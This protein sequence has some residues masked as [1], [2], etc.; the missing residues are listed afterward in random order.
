MDETVAVQEIDIGSLIIDTIN[1]LCQ[2]LFSSI[3]TEIFPLLDKVV[4]IKKDI[5]TSHLERIVGTDTQTGLLVL[6]NALLFAFLIYYG[7][8]LLISSYSGENIES[9]YK[10]FLRL[11]LVAIFM[12]FSLTICTYIIDATSD[13]TT[14]ICSLG[15]NIFGNKIDISF[16]SLIETVSYDSGKE[17]N[18]FSLSGIL[19]GMLSISSFTLIMTFALRYIIIKVLILLSPFAIICLINP[20]TSGL[21]KSWLKCFLTILFL[22]IF[23]SLV[24]LL[25]YAI[26]KETTTSPFRELLLVGTIMALLK[27]NE[28]VKE[29]MGGLNI[30]S[31]FASGLAGVKSIFSR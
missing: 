9:P 23:I 17:L 20:S 24:L 25:S 14:F 29:L 8:K 28:Y 13:I 16:S 2:S 15:Q 27:S 4:F 10:F 1:N 6:A 22:Q 3:N 21:F 26:I 12:N 5:T 11:F 18:I 30:S 31:N 19:S 7:V